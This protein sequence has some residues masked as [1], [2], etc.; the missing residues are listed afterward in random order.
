MANPSG[1]ID[2]CVELSFPLTC[3]SLDIIRLPYGS[4]QCNPLF[5]VFCDKFGENPANISLAWLLKNPIVTAPIIG[6]RT[7]EQFKNSLKSLEIKL[8]DEALR[9]LDEI[10][11]GPGGQ[12]PE[13][14][15]W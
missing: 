3:P 4:D 2:N 13:A 10:W 12:A 14:Y 7:M 11:P 15:A 6:P 9:E 5:L 1:H 8:N